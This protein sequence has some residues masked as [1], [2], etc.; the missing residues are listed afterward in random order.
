M[1]VLC[2]YWEDSVTSTLSADGLRP[3]VVW[4]HP[5]SYATGF[6]PTYGSDDVHMALAH[7]GFVTVS[8][9]QV[10]FGLRILEGGTTFYARHGGRCVC[11]RDTQTESQTVR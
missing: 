1:M 9:D 8:F 7:A 6:T 2:R 3:A 4:L 5:Y 10:G 11:E